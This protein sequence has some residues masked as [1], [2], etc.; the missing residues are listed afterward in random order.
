MFRLRFSIFFQELQKSV[1][2]SCIFSVS[3][4]IEKVSKIAVF[5]SLHVAFIHLGWVAGRVRKVM[6]ILHET[7]PN[8][9]K[10]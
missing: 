5:E 6:Q 1:G 10:I 9:P 8:H 7:Y 4:T 2:Q 3:K